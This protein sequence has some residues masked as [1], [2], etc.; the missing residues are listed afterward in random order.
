MA[1][2]AL[3]DLTIVEW[4]QGLASAFSAKAFA[5]LGAEV[6]KVE[7]PGGDPARG[8][9]PFAGDVPDPERSGQFLYLNANKRGI[10]L[11]L[12]VEQGRAVLRDLA[13]RADVMIS[14]LHPTRLDALALD[15]PSLG[16]LNPRL[17]LT[18]ISPF[19]QTGPY[20][21]YQGGDLIAWQ[22]GGT[23]DGTP[24]NAVTEPAAQPPLRGG[25]Y[26]ADYLT[27]WTAASATMVAVF[28]R[29]TY[30]TG[31]LVDVSAMEAVANMLRPNFAQYSYDRQTVREDRVKLGSPWIYPCKDGHISTSTLRDHWWEALK[32]LMGRPD[33]A[34]SDV[35]ANPLSR[36]Q[37]AD[38]LDP[39]L[40]EWFSRYT[41]AELYPMLQEKGVPC[42]PVQSI[43]ELLRSPQYEARGF[44]VEQ[45][46]PV[47]GP[48][49]QPG[50]SIRYSA[51]PWRVR[52]PAPLLGQHTEEVLAEALGYDR[53][54]IAALAAAGAI[55]SLP[56]P[57][58]QRSAP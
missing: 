46:H 44:F 43:G 23:G 50:P 5:D 12:E 53:A 34:D 9:E 18:L 37:N 20:R 25:G 55:V 35:F 40:A 56:Q 51:T 1:E 39:L 32:D 10:A 30:G 29:E 41:R 58:R 17:I 27:G 33:W 36:R 14:D 7:P 28:H 16:T 24:F 38:A 19:G 52:R 22:M 57:V 49:R 11:D 8:A 13:Q 42:F 26:Q 21:N 2:A 3:A 31:Q 4:G 15:Y 48:V 45:Q 54:R 47:A 6:I